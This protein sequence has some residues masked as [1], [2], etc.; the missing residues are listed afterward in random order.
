MAVHFDFTV[1]DEDADIIFQV[2]KD[3]LCRCVSDR[4]E[5]MVEEKRYEANLKLLK[6]EKLRDIINS[7]S[8]TKE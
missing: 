8:H 5:L 7:M 2:L 4:S 1:S 6:I 3:R